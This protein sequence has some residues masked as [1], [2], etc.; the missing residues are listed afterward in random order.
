MGRK[1]HN[2]TTLRN[3]LFVVLECIE[4]NYKNLEMAIINTCFILHQNQRMSVSTKKSTLTGGF[5]IALSYGNRMGEKKF[6]TYIRY[7]I[8]ERSYYFCNYFPWKAVK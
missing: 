2:K 8:I 3:Q 5:T 6:D 4:P 7:T 1:L